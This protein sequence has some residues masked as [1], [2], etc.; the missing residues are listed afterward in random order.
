FFAV[1]DFAPGKNYYDPWQTTLRNVQQDVLYY[2]TGGD[3]ESVQYHLDVLAAP[4]VTA[5]TLDYDFPPYTGTPK[6]TQVEGGNVE[7]IEGT[8]V[9]VH[10]QTNQAA[11]A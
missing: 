6:R 3:A 5:V 10:A 11:R 9:T 7:A 4:M 8:I 2:L 1:S